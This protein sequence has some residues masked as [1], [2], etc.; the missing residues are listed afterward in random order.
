[1]VE[2]SDEPL[3]VPLAFLSIVVCFFV[4]GAAALRIAFHRNEADSRS[5][6]V[7][8]RE[9]YGALSLDFWYAVASL[10]AVVLLVRLVPV[11][12]G[13]CADA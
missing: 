4:L 1:M 9:W 11:A 5:S 13:G 8:L 2:T 10:M 6:W 3:L 12:L 7:G